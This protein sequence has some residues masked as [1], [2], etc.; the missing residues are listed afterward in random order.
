[1][2]LESTVE[3]TRWFGFYLIRLARKLCGFLEA[4]QGGRGRGRCGEVGCQDGI[5]YANIFICR[6]PNVLKEII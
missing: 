3:A 2:I 4:E 6:N 5:D 1:M